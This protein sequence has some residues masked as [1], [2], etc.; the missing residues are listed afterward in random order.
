MREITSQRKVPIKCCIQRVNAG[1]WGDSSCDA[2]SLFNTLNVSRWF[3]RLDPWLLPRKGLTDKRKLCRGFYSCLLAGIWN[4]RLSESVPGLYL[5]A[6][7]ASGRHCAV[8][9]ELHRPFSLSDC[10][11]LHLNVRTARA[12]LRN[13]SVCLNVPSELATLRQTWK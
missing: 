2:I 1:C 7:S 11:N 3:K 10:L 13:L 4:Q 6:P 12:T 9:V 5:T 8:H